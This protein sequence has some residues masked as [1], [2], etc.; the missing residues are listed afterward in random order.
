MSRRASGGEPTG[1]P[2][3]SLVGKASLGGAH[4]PKGAHLSKAMA[5]H[6]RKAVHQR[7]RQDVRW[8]S[9]EPLCSSYNGER[10]E[11]VR[12]SEKQEEGAEN[13]KT[14]VEGD[15]E[16]K[17]TKRKNRKHRKCRKTRRNP[18]TVQGKK[19]QPTTHAQCSYWIMQSVEGIE[20]CLR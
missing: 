8:F 5:V 13:E 9:Y 15:G 6:L 10:K 4:S 12:V 3:R 19:K 14:M 11:G 1:T 20:I 7:M 17:E 16:A 2:A 18:G